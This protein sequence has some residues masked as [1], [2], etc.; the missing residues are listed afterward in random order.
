MKNKKQLQT[1]A[2]GSQDL[3]RALLRATRDKHGITQQ[4]I[5]ERLGTSAMY[6]NRFEKGHAPMSLGHINTFRKCLG[7]SNAEVRKALVHDFFND[8]IKVIK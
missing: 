6:V 3:T 8:V 7:L 2:K 1:R 4:K 5:A